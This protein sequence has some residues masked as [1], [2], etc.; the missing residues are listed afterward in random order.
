M[1]RRVNTI[2]GWREKESFPLS[3]GGIGHAALQFWFCTPGMILSAKAL[4]DKRSSS[5]ENKIREPISGNLWWCTGH[6]QIVEA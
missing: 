5:T 4:P 6:G 2:E 3:R 1:S